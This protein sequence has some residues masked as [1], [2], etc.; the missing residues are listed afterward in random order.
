M[1]LNPFSKISDLWSQLGFDDP[2]SAYRECF[3]EDLDNDIVELQIKWE[4]EKKRIEDEM[5]FLKIDPLNMNDKQKRIYD[6]GF[7]ILDLGNNS[8]CL[9][10]VM[11]IH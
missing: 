2:I 6:K 1:K 11:A 7:A 10:K 5:N 9:Y 3:K 4:E 8:D